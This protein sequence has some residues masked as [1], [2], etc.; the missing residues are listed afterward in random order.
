M[1]IAVIEHFTSLPPGAAPADLVA[2]GRAMLEA[3]AAD[4]TRRPGVEVV[5]AGTRR[6]FVAA[7]R[8]CAAALVIAPEEDGIL[9]GLCLAVERRGCLL[10]GS[11]SASV[12]L[13][14]D[15]LRAAR[16]LAAA[17]LPT[18]RTE[19]VPFKDAPRRLRAW[20]LPFVLKPRDGCGGR[21]VVIVRRIR[22]IDRGLEVV[23]G[24]TRRAD[25]LAQD[26]VAGEAASVSLIV[27]SRVVDLGLNSQRM[28]WRPTIEYLGGETDWG[29]VR[30]GEGIAFAR[31]AV[32]ALA[33]AGAPLCGYVGVDLLLGRDGVSVIEVNPRLTTS[34]IGL[35]L[36]V[37]E[38]LAGLILDAA[39]GGP[40]PERVTRVARCR[41]LADGSAILLAGRRAPGTRAARRPRG[42]E[43]DRW[44]TTSAGTSA[45]SI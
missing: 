23:R 25:F 3:C 7:L 22:D 16:C 29:H 33:T 21:G 2:Q 37:R 45:A 41:F 18:P 35:R 43:R 8:H 26:L 19:S 10:I 12:R 27:G 5:I 31:A 20:R 14:A 36:S 15:K 11:A 9:A 1:K 39:T 40:L 30:A 44:R 24:A 38:N 28:R 32:A 4:L 34:Y 13:A 6:T 17:G 42:P